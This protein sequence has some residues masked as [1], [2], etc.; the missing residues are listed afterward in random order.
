MASKEIE[1]TFDW[2]IATVKG[3][4]KA[5]VDMKCTS[6]HDDLHNHFR[7]GIKDLDVMLQNVNNS[8]S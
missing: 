6:W 7:A 5:I 1:H 8:V 4:G 2:H 3:I